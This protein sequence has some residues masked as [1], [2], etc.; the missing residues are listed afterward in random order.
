MVWGQ[1]GFPTWNDKQMAG[2]LPAKQNVEDSGKY[3]QSVE[4]TSWIFYLSL[5][6]RVKIMRETW[7]N[8]YSQSLKELHE[9]TTSYNK[10]NMERKDGIKE[11]EVSKEICK[12]CL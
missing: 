4:E 8:Y 12:T 2:N 5:L 11:R 10:R 3:L 7:D 1:E 6:R 9:G